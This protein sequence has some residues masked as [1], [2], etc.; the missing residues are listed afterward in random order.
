MNYKQIALLLLI[1]TQSTLYANPTAKKGKFSFAFFT[2]I[3]LNK[4]DNNC[5]QGLEK[6]I[7]SAANQT[8]DTLLCPN[9]P[10]LLENNFNIG[11]EHHG[12]K[13]M[14]KYLK[15]YLRKFE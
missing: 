8:I 11:R 3:H 10:A 5:F 13:V 7:E 1:F 14:E 2:D 4:G 15:E 6:A 9:T 12:F